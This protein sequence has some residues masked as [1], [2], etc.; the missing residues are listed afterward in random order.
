MAKVL[1]PT[2][3][4]SIAKETLAKNGYTVVQDAETPLAEL[5]KAHPDAI[6]LVVR[7]EKVTPAVM[8]SLPNL[9]T[10][11]RAG[12]GYDTIDTKYA[13]QKGIDVMNTPGANANA[14]AE[15]VIA[16]V[17]A[18]YRFIV[19]GDTTTRQGLWEKK[20]Y[21]GSELT[22]KTVGIV[23]FGNI[24]RLVAKRLAGFEVRILG[25]DP[26]LTPARAAEFGIEL[27]S[28]EEIFA[29]A[30]IVTV[31]IPGSKG[32]AN[33]VGAPL[34]KLMK[35]GAVLVNCARYGVIDEEALR[36]IKKEKKLGYCTD[37]YP[38]DAPGA[39]PM[40]DIADIMLP[41][42]GAST[43][44]ANLT[45]AR[46]AAEQ[47]I[48]YLEQ[49]ITTFVVNKD[50]PD[51]L[52][53]QYQYLAYCIARI[54]HRYLGNLPVRRIECSFY[55]SL[56]PF[57]KWFMSPIVAGI[58]PESKAARV[59]AEDAET[60]LRDKGISVEIREPDAGKKYGNSITIDLFA[61]EG[62]SLQEV[63]IRGTIAEGLTMISRI[64]DFQRLY[65][66]PKGSSFIAVYKDRPGVLA[67]I[68]AAL[69]WAGINIE[70]IH[71]PHDQKG[72]KSLAVVKVNQPVPEAIVERIKQE[73]EAEVA[74]SCTVS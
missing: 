30:D 37:V 62:S 72:M 1:I 33:L 73:I 27:A 42:L 13:R 19:P 58:S 52:D 60:Y 7:S 35:K 28:L 59:L 43:N 56:Q 44:E 9:K 70:D 4:E 24:G 46:R 67:K 18:H 11:V 55:G 26:I 5:A 21:M 51:G 68:T 36:A 34:L 22:G 57:S 6:A 29:Q 31:H 45:A 74:F 39:K 3:L 12:A 25:Y 40:A 65:F 8:D 63:S 14:V 53:A 2:K 48:A 32:T 38:E 20:H 10:V 15:E 54:G 47:L 41:H 69:A 23:G 50:L 61:G 17:L 16:M 49:G 64:D 66:E 71:A